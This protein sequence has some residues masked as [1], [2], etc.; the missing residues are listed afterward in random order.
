[1]NLSI[2]LCFHQPTFGAVL[3]KPL[4]EALQSIVSYKRDGGLWKR[5]LNAHYPIHF[6]Q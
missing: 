5:I 1:M 6:C 2:K 3:C 4:Y